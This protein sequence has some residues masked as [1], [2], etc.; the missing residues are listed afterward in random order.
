M[1]KNYPAVRNI[2][3][4]CIFDSCE[5]STGLREL[6]QKSNISVDE[7]KDPHEEMSLEG[8]DTKKGISLQ[9]YKI[10]DSDWIEHDKNVDYKLVE[11]R[12]ANPGFISVMNE[13]TGSYL[14]REFTNTV[15]RTILYNESKT[16][17]EIFEEIQNKLHDDRKQQIVMTFNNGTHQL[18]FLKNDESTYNVS[19]NGYISVPKTTNDD[20]QQTTKLNDTP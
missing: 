14:I 20:E 7:Y 3:R 4:I 6:I 12:A 8:N 9:D 1:S 19:S 17:Q 11:I 10:D 5:G 13:E 2:P 18:M 15:S 16:I